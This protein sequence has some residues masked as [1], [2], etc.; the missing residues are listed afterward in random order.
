MKRI[1]LF[2]VFAVLFALPVTAQTSLTG[3]IGTDQHATPDLMVMADHEVGRLLLEPWIEGFSHDW[4]VGVDAILYGFNKH[5][6]LTAGGDTTG[7][8][9]G[10]VL[11][12]YGIEGRV[13][14][15]TS[16]AWQGIVWR[17]FSPIPNSPWYLQVWAVPATDNSKLLFGVGR[18]IK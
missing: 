16:G 18:T 4:F 15:H 13:M 2:S 9:Y 1:V 3:Y 14:R 17:N 6:G 5:V 12:A 11:Q 10:F 7:A 8:R